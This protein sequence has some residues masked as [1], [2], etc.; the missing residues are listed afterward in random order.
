MS[1]EIIPTGLED[2]DGKATF[3]ELCA[4][5]DSGMD[6]T[7]ALTWARENGF[8][9]TEEQLDHLERDREIFDAEAVL[10]GTG[11]DDPVA[12]AQRRAEEAK[13]AKAAAP[14]TRQDKVRAAFGFLVVFMIV[15]WAI[16]HFI[17][18]V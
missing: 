9:A 18:N 4:L 11:I 7:Q 16:M 15:L 12:E 3:E 6:E 10:Y 14:L 17:I 1:E 5:L 13:A 8:V 2:N